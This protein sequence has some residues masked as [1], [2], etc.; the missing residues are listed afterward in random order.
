MQSHSPVH[1][2]E[3]GCIREGTSQAGSRAGMVAYPAA[4]NYRVPVS[5]GVGFERQDLTVKG[6][7]RDLTNWIPTEVNCI[8]CCQFLICGALVFCVVVAVWVLA[9]GILQPTFSADVGT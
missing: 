9:S 5:T 2:S 8:F 7:A 3:Q 6:Q 4:Y 1:D